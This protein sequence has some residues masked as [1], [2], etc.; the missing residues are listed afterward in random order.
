[1]KIGIITIF[2]AN[3]YGA[4]LQAFALQKKLSL[5]GHDSELI[6][7]P[8]YKHPS[9][10]ASRQ[11]RPIFDMGF[12][13]RVKERVYPFWTALQSISI[14]EDIKRKQE[15]MDAFHRTHSRLSEVCY[16]SMEALYAADWP[17]DLFITGSDQ[18]WNPR[19]N[20]SLDPYFLTFAPS[21]KP[22]VSYASSFG[23]P[24]LPDHTKRVYKERLSAFERLSV[25]EAQG[26]KIV[27][28]LLG[29]SPEHVLDPTLLLTDVEWS[30]V[31]VAVDLPTPYVLIYDLVPHSK[32]AVVARYVASQIRGAH[33]VR[34]RNQR[35]VGFRSQPDILDVDDAGPSEFLG[36]FQGASAVVT[37][38]LHGT[39]FSINF[40]KPF[41]PVISPRMR[42]AGR[43]E[44]LLETVGL[45]ERIIYE[46][47][48]VDMTRLAEIDYDTVLGRLER[49]RDKSVNYLEQVCSQ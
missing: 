14:G 26:V 32:L 3:S 25:R 47:L 33:I 10:V 39:A 45:S 44:S 12:K 37:N 20:S 43:N 24:T 46:N 9:H 4:E 5:M 7:Y 36:L 15:R 29:C 11:S 6:D 17:Y 31:A 22:R 42:N 2:K 34:I 18:V 27:H 13:N 41:Y 49:E 1:L 38:S 21:D 40:R 30:D 23:V 35:G 16:N 48:N 19:M 28:D 8:F